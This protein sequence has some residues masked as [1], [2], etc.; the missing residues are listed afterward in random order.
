MVKRRTV[1]R[2]GPYKS[3]PRVFSGTVLDGEHTACVSII[4]PR[5]SLG[6]SKGELGLVEKF[7]FRG[8]RGRAR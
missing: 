4:A 6:R 2:E 7:E 5:E 8:I 3:S 1:A